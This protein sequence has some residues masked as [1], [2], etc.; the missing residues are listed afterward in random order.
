MDDTLR[1]LPAAAHRTAPL[2]QFDQMLA[3]LD[4]APRR[5]PALVDAAARRRI[6]THE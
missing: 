2:A 3:A 1:S 4:A 5:V 6:F